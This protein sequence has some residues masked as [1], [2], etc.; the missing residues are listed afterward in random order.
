MNRLSISLI[1]LLLIALV[2]TNYKEMGFCRHNEPTYWFVSYSFVTNNG[3]RSGCEVLSFS[4]RKDFPFD[5]VSNMLKEQLRTNLVVIISFK[6]ISEKTGLGISE[7]INKQPKIPVA[8]KLPM[9]I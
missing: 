4:E 2:G 1:A 6:K 8:K 3:E 5:T 9:L 7:Y